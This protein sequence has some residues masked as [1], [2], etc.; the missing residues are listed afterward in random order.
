M[1]F[2]YE[3]ILKLH[4]CIQLAWLRIYSSI[5]N[6]ITCNSYYGSKSDIIRSGYGITINVIY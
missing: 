6:I 4:T 5:L 1:T 2:L 3:K